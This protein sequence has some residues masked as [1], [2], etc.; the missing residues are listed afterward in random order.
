VK[1]RAALSPRLLLDL[2]RQPLWPAAI[3]ATLAGFAYRISC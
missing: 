2:V 3:G 1:R